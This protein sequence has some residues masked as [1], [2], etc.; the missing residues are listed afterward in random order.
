M[1]VLFIAV[2]FGL[3]LLRVDADEPSERAGDSCY[4]Q[5]PRDGGN[6]LLL[7][8]QCYHD[9]HD[10]SGMIATYE[11]IK[12][13]YLGSNPGGVLQQG[14][15]AALAYERRHDLEKATETIRDAVGISGL[16]RSGKTAASINEANGYS[17]VFVRDFDRLDAA[18]VSRFR[19]E[20][21]READQQS[22]A[23]A[24]ATAAAVASDEARKTGL[25]KELQAEALHAA[26]SARQQQ[27][28]LSRQR[29]KAKAPVQV[30]C[31]PDV[32]HRYDTALAAI[33]GR[34]DGNEA[35]L[36]FREARWIHDCVW[37]EPGLQRYTDLKT[38]VFA[39]TWYASSETSNPA[40]LA[41]AK[42]RLVVML[43]AIH[44]DPNL[45][46]GDDLFS[47]YPARAMAV[48]HQTDLAGLTS[49]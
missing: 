34:D 4:Q 18:E 47:T 21:Q 19:D 23:R 40:D 29:E 26:Q 20:A 41:V 49:G 48:P 25:Q 24:E 8:D 5:Y 35:K 37:A 46:E 42:S 30:G 13:T 32:I 28:I 15:W 36:A 22:A 33:G 43:N 12:H 39:Y 16:A 3:S 14:Y 1:R 11:K 17:K 44:R 10:D 9:A 7:R 2:I 45:R 6:Q 27:L 31:A 38:A